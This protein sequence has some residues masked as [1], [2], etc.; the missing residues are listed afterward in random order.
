MNPT[1]LRSAIHLLVLSGTCNGEREIRSWLCVKTCRSHRCMINFCTLLNH[2]E[3][4]WL[5]FPLWFLLG[6]LCSY[7]LDPSRLPLSWYENSP[8]L[9]SKNEKCPSQPM[10]PISQ[11]TTVIKLNRS[12]NLK[13]MWDKSETSVHWNCCTIY[14]FPAFL[15]PDPKPEPHRH[16]QSLQQRV[17]RQLWK[18]QLSC[19]C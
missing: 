12:S 13:S 4:P 10:T 14:I 1:T 18:R 11:K 2:A 5:S 17:C 3:A 16:L 8:N 19:H 15:A 7:D 6:A 9:L